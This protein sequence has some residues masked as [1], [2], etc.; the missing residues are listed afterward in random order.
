MANWNAEAIPNDARLFLR[1]HRNWL[2]EGAATSGAFKYQ[3]NQDDPNAS[4]GLSTDWEKYSTPEE[5]Q[6]R[7][8]PDK[9]A[10]NYAVYS[11]VAGLVR[12]VESQVVNH[13]PDEKRNNRAH[14]DVQGA[15]NE[16]EARKR[17]RDIAVTEIP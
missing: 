11:L 15:I 14:T 1:V 5:T 9:P 16:A 12:E 3:T 17:M 13:T 7:F 6:G 2:R 10:E 8:A 4:P